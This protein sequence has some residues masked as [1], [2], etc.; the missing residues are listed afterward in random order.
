MDYKVT[1]ATKMILI[2]YKGDPDP[3]PDRQTVTPNPFLVAMCARPCADRSLSCKQRH[4]SRL[5]Q[6]TGDGSVARPITSI[7]RAR[8]QLLL[9]AHAQIEVELAVQDA[10]APCWC[11][12]SIIPPI[13]TADFGWG[14]KMCCR[15]HE[16]KS[17][18]D[19]CPKEIRTTLVRSNRRT[20]SFFSP[21]RVKHCGCHAWCPYA[22]VEW[23]N[24][25]NQTLPLCPGF[26]GK[27]LAAWDLGCRI[28][29]LDGL[30]IPAHGLLFIFSRHWP[31]E[32]RRMVRRDRYLRHQ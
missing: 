19:L 28:R 18:F 14:S 21:L 2:H 6:C 9:N 32:I 11:H 12:F 15:A 20:F 27:Q 5:C 24:W 30:K 29:F 31:T 16:F 8:G 26:Q 1:L 7:A 25:P 3:L 22:Y 4:G 10:P 17:R 13:E 23:N